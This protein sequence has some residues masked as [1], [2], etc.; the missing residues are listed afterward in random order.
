M[1][2]G[3][4]PFNPGTSVVPSTQVEISVSCRNLRDRDLFSKSDPVCI[5]YTKN[6]KSETFYEFGRTETIKDTLNPDFI[7]KFVMSYYFEEC[8]HLKF[9]L[10]DVDSANGSLDQQDFLGYLECT[11]GE[12]VGCGSKLEKKLLRD[13]E[14]SKLACIR[15]SAID[16]GKIIL[17][18]E[19]V[20]IC[21]DKLT[22]QFQATNLDKKDF[23]GKSDPFL[24]FYRANEDRSF[25]AVHKT[26]VIKNTLNPTWQPFNVM[27][28][29][30]CNGDYDRVIKVECYDWDRDGGHDFIGEFTTNLQ[31]LLKGA[32][33]ENRYEAINPKK[34]AKKKNYKNS[35]EVRLMFCKVET[36][37]SFLDYIKS[38]RTQLN[39]TV[40]IDFT[41][42]NG[43]PS[44]S[45][46][47]HYYNPYQMNQ[48]AAAIQAVGEIIQ[49]YDSDKLFPT[50]GFGARLPDGSV[51]HEFA[52][53]CNPNNPYC[54]GIQGILQA[55]YDSLQRVQLYGPTNFSPVINHVAKFASNVQDGSHYFILLII[56]DGV[57]TDMNQTIKS[58]I[59][60][61]YLPM[62]III[63]GVGS[64]DFEAMNILDSDD[65]LLHSGQL[66]AQRDIV[67]FVPFRDFLGGQYGSRMHVSQAYLA[68]EVLAE[69]P[70]QFLSYMK[71]HG[72]LPASPTEA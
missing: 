36:I 61:S 72:I 49:D 13:A 41:A 6:F 62:S 1:A 17:R 27:A 8:Q 51:S 40:A 24:I 2:A 48:Y 28:S 35:G 9:E 4:A 42:S 39:F 38:G 52:L 15:G 56:T 21:K 22:L 70:E 53:N 69:I 54:A 23:F 60:A 50:L 14:R 45:T 5:L 59:Q 31:T 7:K 63:V 44:N 34:K 19:E 30:L 57:I 3:I 10:Y 32:G 71:L 68:K 12:I 43:N 16:N 55:Y 64:A 29:V 18:A 25:T 66:A 58:I 11:L 67:Q 37:Y 47:L 26:E 20:N 33:P 46:S 65:G